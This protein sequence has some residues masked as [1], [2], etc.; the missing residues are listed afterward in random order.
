MGSGCRV[1]TREQA[2]REDAQQLL[3]CVCAKCTDEE[4]ASVRLG[5]RV[6]LWLRCYPEVRCV[7]NAPG[8]P[9]AHEMNVY[10]L[11]VDA[12]LENGRWLRCVVERAR[13]GGHFRWRCRHAE[14][15]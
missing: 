14:R 5:Q 13:S 1:L 9:P 15:K 8:V 11:H 12:R 2:K 7:P 6:T 3:D 10:V 4:A